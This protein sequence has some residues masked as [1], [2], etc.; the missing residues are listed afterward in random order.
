MKAADKLRAM[1][2]GN[3]AESMGRSP[4]GGATAPHGFQVRS[5]D[6]DRHSGLNRV[7]GAFQ[8]PLDR[9]VPDPN[10]PRKEFDE[11]AIGRLAESLKERGQLQA[12]RVRFD[13]DLDRWVI[14]SGERRFRA[15]GLAGLATLAAVEASAPMTDDEV[16]EDQLVENCVREDLRPVEQAHAFRALMAKRGWSAIRLAKALS[17]NDSSV[18]RALALLDL[19]CTVQDQVEQ[20]VIAPATAYEISKVPDAD[21]QVEL[22]AQV[23]AGKLSRDATAAAVKQRSGVKAKGKAPTS[24]VFRTEAGPRFTVEH[25]RGLTTDL[26]IAGLDEIRARLEAEGVS[27]G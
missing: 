24:R 20:G 18:V 7:K 16:L 11:G 6:Q 23:V 12:I 2:G 4:A 3:I 17:L 9:I 26:I 19:P 27:E 1:A 8:I 5:P 15:A 14:I 10:Q 22:A 13:A 25:K 21:A